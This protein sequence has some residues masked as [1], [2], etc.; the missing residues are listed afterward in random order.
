MPDFISSLKRKSLTGMLKARLVM[1]AILCLAG[2]TPL[3]AQT[4]RITGRVSDSSGA[5]IPDASVV[6][7]QLSVNQQRTTQ[8]SSDGY[9]TVPDLAPG[10]YSIAVNDKGFKPTTQ[11]GIQLQVD[12]SLRLDFTLEV[13]TLNEQVVV[14]AQAPLLDTESQSVGQTVQGK[15]IINLPLLGRNPYALGGLVPG[16]RIS[17]GM[18]DLPVDQISTSSVSINGAP[19]NANEFLLDGAPNTAAAQNQPI[20]Y[21]NADSVQEFRVETNNFSAEYGRAAGGVF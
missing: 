18:N 14:E 19:G 4:G 3:L 20:V 10:S 15:Q 16:V 11:T 7:T 6:V 13:G 17:R 21:P 1:I 5:A 2:M 8:T 12:Q 9:Y